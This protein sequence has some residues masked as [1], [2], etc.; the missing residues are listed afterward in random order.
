MIRRHTKLRLNNDQ[1]QKMRAA[2]QFNARL[3]DEVRAIVRP[4]IKTIEIDRFVYEL[5]LIHI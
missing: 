5:S 3:M 4:G 1:Q 2:G